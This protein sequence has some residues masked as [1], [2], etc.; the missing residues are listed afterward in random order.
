MI[1]KRFNKTVLM[2]THYAEDNAMA[3]CLNRRTDQMLSKI[4]KPL[5][6]DLNWDEP[7]YWGGPVSP[8][9]VWMLHDSRWDYGAT[10]NIND[11]WSI[12]SSEQMFHELASGNLPHYYRFFFGFTSWTGSQLQGELEGQPPWSRRYSWLIVNEPSQEWITETD[13]E[14]LYDQSLELCGTQAVEH[15]L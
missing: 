6:L 7:L 9:T 3:L 13:A 10:L 12:S 11:Q 8:T 2:L 15:W 5:G 1:D 4:I 14:D